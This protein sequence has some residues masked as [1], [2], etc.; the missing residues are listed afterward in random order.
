MRRS[1]KIDVRN[2]VLPS[3]QYREHRIY[4]YHAIEWPTNVFYDTCAR[5]G[6]DTYLASA[7]NL[8]RIRRICRSTA[9]LN[10]KQ[11]RIRA[12]H[13]I[14]QRHRQTRRA[15]AVLPAPEGHNVGRIY[16]VRIE[17]EH[18]RR[19]RDV[20]RSLLTCCGR[21]AKREQHHSE[22]CANNTAIESG[23]HS[24]TPWSRCTRH[25]PTTIKRGFP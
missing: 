11:E 3:R 10:L 12:S 2:D 15:V 7:E 23:V 20:R 8:E 14:T 16:L 19:R 9:R 25:L 5:T 24:E 17:A 22:S 4:R 6:A 21:G 13:A 1:V 18:D